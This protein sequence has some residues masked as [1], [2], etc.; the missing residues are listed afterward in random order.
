LGKRVKTLLGTPL[1]EFESGLRRGVSAALKAEKVDPDQSQFTKR[2]T[3]R[4]VA[5][6]EEHKE[7]PF[8]VYLPHVMPHVP[9]FAS[10]AFKG[11]SAAGLYGDVVEEL[12]WSMG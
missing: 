2:F 5:F 3:E 12:D 4:S 1:R 11:K 6:M 10:E 8:F 9:I 7:E